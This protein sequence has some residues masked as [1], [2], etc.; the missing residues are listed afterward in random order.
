MDKINNKK[1]NWVFFGSSEFSVYVLEELKIHSILPKLIVTTLDKPKGRKLILTPTPVKIWARNNNIDCISPVSLKKQNS[2]LVSK[3]KSQDYD[4]FLVASYGKLIPKEI[5]EIPTFKTLNIHPSLLPKYRGASPIQSQILNNEKEIGV[6]IMQIEET[7]D[8][9]PIVIQKNV[10]IENWPIGRKELEKILATEG[11]KLFAHIL[12][13]WVIGAI[14]PIMQ[15]EEKATY[16]Q[17][18]EKEDGL[19]NLEDA[20]YENLLKIKAFEEWPTAF[21]FENNKRIIITDA[22]FENGS[23]KILKVIPEGKKE[24][25]FTDFLRGQQN[26][27]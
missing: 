19:I 14:D 3:L 12:P 24:M 1:T 17:K 22:K 27:K 5:F 21:Y 25:L 10:A 23:L 4:L 2:D 7:M 20:P 26:Q 11:S 9:G 6:T 18:I 15:N 16:C 13:E 8:T